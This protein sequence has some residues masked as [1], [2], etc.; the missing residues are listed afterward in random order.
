MS[1]KIGDLVRHKSEFLR[2]IFWC[3]DVPLN[4]KIVE[5]GPVRC[6]LVARVNWSDGTS[7]RIL[8]SNLEADP[9]S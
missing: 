1:F 9:R 4:G 8:V 2:N 6:P 5:L 7:T 3:L